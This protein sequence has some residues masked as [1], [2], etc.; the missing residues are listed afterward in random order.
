MA[1][2]DAQIEHLADEYLVG[3]FQTL[4]RD[5]IQDIARRVR[6]TERLTETAELMAKSMSEHGFSTPRIYADVMSTLQADAAYQRAVLENTV[7]YKRMVA[8]AIEKTVREAE[9]AGDELVAAAGTMAYNNDLSMWTQAGQDLSVPNQMDQIVRSFRQSVTGELRNLTGTTGFRGTMF[10]LT[11]VENA[12]QRALDV[13]L[14]KVAT[15]TFSLDA[16]CESAIRELAHSGLRSIDYASGRSY[17]L[18][19]AVRMCVRTASTQ[20]AGRITMA[21]VQSTGV[22]HIR[23]S[24]HAGARPEHAVWQGKVFTLDELTSTEPGK[25]AYGTATG[26]CGVNCRHTFYPYWPGASVDVPYEREPDPVTVDGRRYTYY[27]ATQKQRSMEREIRA[28]KREAYSAASDEDRAVINRK[29]HAKT[30]EYHRFSEAVGIRPKDNRLRVVDGVS[31]PARKATS[32]KPAASRPSARDVTKKYAEKAKRGQGSVSYDPGYAAGRHAG[33]IRVAEWLRDTFGGD[34]QLLQEST[35]GGV[36]TP[37]TLWR[38]KFWEFK[39]A[40]SINGADKQLQ[41]AL[42]QIK[43]NPGGVVLDITDVVVMEDLEDQ[44]WRRFVRSAAVSEFD[45]MLRYDGE[46]KKII[47]YKK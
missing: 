5:V 6:K 3:I 44:L 37:D 33:E 35:V 21:N 46:L 34:V 39:A 31:K 40:C 36:K 20:M 23:T 7:E 14:I 41:S 16:A 12:Y 30:S 4:E 8:E 1:L 45:L 9:E 22:R 17:Q 25:P 27:D 10:G 43:D 32:A 42:K 28:L 18:D 38:G 29:I 24:S 15:G 47:R 26:L 11:G 13:S 2:T 19:T